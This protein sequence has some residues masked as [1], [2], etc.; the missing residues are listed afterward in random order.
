MRWPFCIFVSCCLLAGI[1]FASAVHGAQVFVENG[2][3][4]SEAQFNQWV[5]GGRRT[6]GVDADSEIAVAVEAVDRACRLT[7]SQQEKLRLAG[8]GDF[9]RFDQRVAE[10]RAKYAD[11]MH[12]PNDIGRI[13]QEI[14]PLN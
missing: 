12:D 11:K 1:G 10:L 8:R 5:Y 3:Q 14:Q 7:E 4:L 2:F 9:A 13:H 6:T